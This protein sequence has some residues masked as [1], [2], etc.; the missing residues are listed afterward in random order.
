MANETP[1]D[2]LAE[3]EAWRAVDPKN[4]RV[5]VHWTENRIQALCE[6]I[7]LADPFNREKPFLF[8][9]VGLN[10]EKAILDALNK[11]KGGG[12]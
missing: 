7:N 1:R 2:A 4:R 5:S 11:V 12:K 6:L 3:L 8:T 9:G 10:L